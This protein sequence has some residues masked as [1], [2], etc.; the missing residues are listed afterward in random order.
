MLHLRLLGGFELWEDGERVTALSGPRLQAMFAYLFLHRNAALSR[1]RLAF[2]FWPDVSEDNAY[3]SLRKSLHSLKQRVPHFEQIIEADRHTLQWR[4]NAPVDVDVLNF[5]VLVTQ[6]EPSVDALQWMCSLYQG[7]LLEGFSDDWLLNARTTLQGQFQ[8]FMREGIQRLEAQRRYS[9]AIGFTQRLLALD[10]YNEDIQRTMMRLQALQGDRAAAMRTY[11]SFAKTL[12][13]ELA[14]IPDQE[15]RSAYQHILRGESPGQPRISSRPPGLVGRCQEWSRLLQ[16]WESTRNRGLTSV[17]LRGEVGLG[18]T[19]LA[20]EFSAWMLQQGLSAALISCYPLERET[21]Y[22]GLVAL[23]KTLP[24]QNLEPGH[25]QE[26]SLLV[27]E[28]RAESSDRKTS[29]Q[30]MPSRRQHIFEAATAALRSQAPLLLVVDD[31]QWCDVETLDWLQGVFRLGTSAR[32]LLLFLLRPHDAPT[33]SPVSRLLGT[34]KAMDRLEE[35]SLPPLSAEETAQLAQQLSGQPLQPAQLAA[36]VAESEGNPLF[37]HELARTELLASPDSRGLKLPSSFQSVWETRLSALTESARALLTCAAVLGRAVAEEV[38]RQVSGLEFLAF[39]DALDLLLARGFLLEDLDNF[40]RFSHGKLADYIYSSLTRARRRHLHLQVAR[41]L[42]AS[43]AASRDRLA[44]ELA[45]HFEKAGEMREAIRHC[46]QAAHAAC[47]MYAWSQA[48]RC[49]EQAARL[50]GHDDTDLD[51]QWS[52]WEGLD[53]LLD[54]QARY[55]EQPAVYQRLQQLAL[56]PRAPAWWLSDVRRREANRLYRMGHT[57]KALPLVTTAVL[58]ARASGHKE[59]EARSLMVSANI[60][61][62]LGLTG[63]EALEELRRAARLGEELNDEVLR[64]DAESHLS[65]Q[66]YTRTRNYPAPTVLVAHAHFV[67]DKAAELAGPVLSHPPVEISRPE[68]STPH[69]NLLELRALLSRSANLKL[70][71]NESEAAIADLMLARDISLQMQDPFAQSYCETWLGISHYLTRQFHTAQQ[72]FLSS[73]SISR[74]TKVLRRQTLNLGWLSELHLDLGDFVQARTLLDESEALQE[75]GENPCLEG[76]LVAT[77]AHLELLA[78]HEAE[79]LRLVEHGLTL[80]R[81]NQVGYGAEVCLY[82]WGGLALLR[83]G[84]LKEALRFLELSQQ[85][86]IGIDHWLYG[87][88]GRVG[89]ARVYRRMGMGSRAEEL[90]KPLALP[91]L[92]RGDNIIR[93]QEVL[94]EYAVLLLS[95]GQ[96]QASRQALMTAHKYLS[97]LM[98]Q[99]P[100]PEAQ[101]RLLQ[102]PNHQEMVEMLRGYSVPSV[103]GPLLHP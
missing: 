81:D 26:L 76:Y 5:E 35:I 18:K 86:E 92:S 17:L 47:T 41:V 100:M 49:F 73:L 22:A 85:A 28:G 46:I 12:R 55:H 101:Q 52:A 82:L 44:S 62:Q 64:V 29:W 71:Q 103:P 56:H 40:L 57:R 59:T 89:L 34:L 42:A 19:R 31:I 9:E 4:V 65:Y 102:H 70:I 94:A 90:L 83:Q 91:L 6:N 33:G 95:Q 24:L 13:Q 75:P 27:P 77:R 39:L 61:L 96:Y 32:L 11:H 84:N 20:E 43:P 58:L 74:A 99:F 78:G 1:Q 51:L 63:D 66:I 72:Y 88:T 54:I 21:P 67:Q 23:L 79:T 14:T 2:T 87:I 15:T 10:S 45:L 36:L 68:A 48:Q 97:E 53:G 98:S 37:V 93:P 8:A 60:R 50:L 80:Q 16:S 7:E 25:Q 69:H 3:G 38:L 30:V